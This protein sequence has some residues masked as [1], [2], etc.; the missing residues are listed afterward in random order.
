M[1]TVQKYCVHCTGKIRVLYIHEYCMRTKFCGTLFFA[2]FANQQVITK[3]KHENVYAY[4]TSLLL[5]AAICE[6]KIAK[7]IRCR[8]FAKYMSHENL[9]A[10]GT[11]RVYCTGILCVLY[12]NTLCTVHEYCV[13]CT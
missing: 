2:N 3:I 7:I 13:Y 11:V 5:Q 1:C 9:Y 12:Q 6:I 10:Y 4:S 8:A